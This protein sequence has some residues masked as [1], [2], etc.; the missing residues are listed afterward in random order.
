MYTLTVTSFLFDIQPSHRSHIDHDVLA[1]IEKH[2]KGEDQVHEGI[3]HYLSAPLACTVIF[4]L[5]LQVTTRRWPSCA[6][7]TR[8]CTSTGWIDKVSISPL[9]LKLP[10][11]TLCHSFVRE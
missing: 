9:V 6:N 2:V 11:L 10:I 8:A 3:P 7:W 1:K 5:M 4:T